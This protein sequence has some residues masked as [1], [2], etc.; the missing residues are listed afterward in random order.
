VETDVSPG[1]LDVPVPFL[2]LQ[3]L[4]ENAILH[5]IDPVPDGGTLQIRATLVGESLEIVVADDGVGVAEPPRRAR[6]GIGLGA[7]RERLALT[8]DRFSL[9][10]ENGDQRGYVVRLS[11]PAS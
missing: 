5:G 9:A 1:A 3:P 11:L 6:N 2:T 7:L 8:Y 10:G 4:V